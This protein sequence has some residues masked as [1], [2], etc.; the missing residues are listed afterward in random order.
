MKVSLYHYLSAFHFLI[1][2]SLYYVYMKKKKEKVNSLRRRRS[3]AVRALIQNRYARPVRLPAIVKKEATSFD[4]LKDA[5]VKMMNVLLIN[6]DLLGG[7]KTQG[8]S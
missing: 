6:M 2:E 7:S 3:T 5:F 1:E 8:R 4:A